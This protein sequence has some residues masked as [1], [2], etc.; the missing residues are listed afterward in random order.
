VRGSVSTT[1]GGVPRRCCG[2]EIHCTAM[3][4]GILTSTLAPGAAAASVRAVNRTARASS[5]RAGTGRE[6][7]RSQSATASP[8]VAA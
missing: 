3:K 6:P 8:T 4:G 7:S 5:P 2:P 1:F